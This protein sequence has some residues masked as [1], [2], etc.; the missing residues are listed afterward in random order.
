MIH[1]LFLIPLSEHN[2]KKEY[3]TLIR[4]ANENNF[5]YTKFRKIYNKHKNKRTL[6]LIT[7]LNNKDNTETDKNYDKRYYSLPFL[8]QTSYKIKKLFHSMN[9]HISLKPPT[10]LQNLFCSNKDKTP[11]TKRSGVYCLTAANGH[12]YIGRTFRKLETRQKEHLN[13]IRKYSVRKNRG[14]YMS[15]IEE[16]KSTFA[17]Y[18]LDLNLNLDDTGF[19]VLFVGDDSR[20]IDNIEKYNILANK[21]ETLINTVSIFPE[22]KM[23]NKN[24]IFAQYLEAA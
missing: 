24:L 22:I 13:E 19:D 18:V 16:I 11:I 17:K 21:N 5:P 9:I 4:I 6:S 7:T 2:F 8:G 10:T 1:R 14:K 20:T 15:G 12:K 23:F 3:N